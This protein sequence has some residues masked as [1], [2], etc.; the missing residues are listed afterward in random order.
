MIR[1]RGRES[2]G[3]RVL[4]AALV[5]WAGD[6]VGADLRL[7]IDTPAGAT[8]VRD[9]RGSVTLRGRV[10]LFE[11][12][13]PA[14]DIVLLIDASEDAA[15]PS[16]AD[17]DGDGRASP[18]KGVG[19]SRWG[20]PVYRF[21][22]SADSIL[23]AEILAARRIVDTWP[24][25]RAR[26]GI[27]VIAS[28]YDPHP[29]EH[30]PRG[31]GASVVLPLTPDRDLVSRALRGVLGDGPRGAS[32][33]AEGIR[34]SVS[35]LAGLPEAGSDAREGVERLIVLLGHRA[36]TFPFGSPFHTAPEDVHLAQDA[37]RAAG[38]AGIRIEGFAFGK[39]EGKALGSLE[40]I[41]A[42]AGGHLARVADPR[43]SR[44]DPA[45]SAAGVVLSAVNE[46]SGGGAPGVQSAPDGTWVAAVP[47]TR[48][49]NRIRLRARAADAT[50]AEQTIVI[51]V[52]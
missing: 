44:L 6:A 29:C 41:L 46:T 8:L 49:E 40:G 24:G 27:V 51:Q 50:Q 28:P 21:R 39:G 1:L 16:G 37:A 38:S 4:A 42:L 14:S 7:S 10:R 17:V 52:P 47:A 32:N 20:V 45:S 22:G 43:G 11:L 36:P 34:L 9:A 31:P 18:G 5:L 12:T 48:G 19:L 15:G 3:R 26:F 25:A 30:G 35:M 2:A 23:A 13:P 33:L